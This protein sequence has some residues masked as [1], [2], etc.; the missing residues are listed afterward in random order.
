MLYAPFTSEATMT[1]FLNE[2]HIAQMHEAGLATMDDYISAV[3]AAYTDQGR[4]DF[5]I[6]PRTNFTVD[7]PGCKR[8]GTLKIGGG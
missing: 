5:E 1:L 4:G 8:P 2:K 6:L 3:E 7:V